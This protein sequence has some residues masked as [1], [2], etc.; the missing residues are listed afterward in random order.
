M[1]KGNGY[2]GQT[3]GTKMYMHT[4]KCTSKFSK[5]KYGY[6]TKYTVHGHVQ[7][8]VFYIHTKFRHNVIALLHPCF[9]KTAMKFPVG[10]ILL[11]QVMKAKTLQ[12]DVIN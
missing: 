3:H 2:A 1:C 4:C 10:V 7:C 12:K 9:A 5:C 11:V 8:T 6:H